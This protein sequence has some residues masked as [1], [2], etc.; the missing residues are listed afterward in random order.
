MP[1][2][3]HLYGEEAGYAVKSQQAATSA[4]RKMIAKTQ[5]MFRLCCV[6]CSVSL[7]SNPKFRPVRP[8][9]A[10]DPQVAGILGRPGGSVNLSTPGVD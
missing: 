7:L 2:R 10:G 8:G 3:D 9:S 6:L 4:I 5:F 1:P